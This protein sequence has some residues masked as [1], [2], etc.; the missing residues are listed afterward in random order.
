M[1]GKSHFSNNP[2]ADLGFD[3]FCIARYWPGY[4][5]SP[6][7]DADK[8]TASMYAVHWYWHPGLVA[9]GKGV[10][11]GPDDFGPDLETA[12]IKDFITRR[13]S[14]PFFVYYPVNLS[15][16]MVRSTNSPTSPG[17]RWNYTDVPE[18]DAQGNKTGKRI[19]GSL[20][21]DLEYVDFL[22]GQIWAQVVA[23]G[24]D[25]KTI[26]MV[27]GDN[28]TAGYGKGKLTSEVALRVPFIVYGPGQVKRTGPCDALVDFADILP[29]LAELAG[30][31]FPDGYALDGK[32]FAPLL[33]GKP[34]TGREWIH[35][36]LGTARWLRDQRW[37]LDGNGTFYDCGNS[38]DETAGYRDVTASTDPEVVAARKRFDTIL[39]TIPAPDRNDPDIGPALMRF[40]QRIK[41]A[42]KAE[43]SSPV[44]GKKSAHSISDPMGSSVGVQASACSGD[45]LKRE[46]QQKPARQSAGS[47]RPLVGAIRWDGWFKDNQWEKNLTDAKW[48]SRLPF[49]ATVGKSGKV[50]VC[51]DSQAVM[52][53]E[54]AYAKAGGLSYWAFC[55]YHSKSKAQVNPYNYGW[56]RYLASKH[57]DGFNFCLL[58]QGP[59]LGPTNE[60]E[61]TVAQFVKLF[62]EPTYQRVCGD[63]PLL[64]V[65]SCDKLIPH[66]GSAKAAGDAFRRLRAASEKGGTG[67]PYI[68]AQIWPNQTAADFLDA[69]GFDA[70]GAYS[71][72]GDTN[73]SADYKSLVAMNRW[74]WNQYKTTGREVVPLVNAGWDGRPRGYPGAW[75]EQAT[76]T[77]VADAVK[78]ALDWNRDNPKTARAQTVLVY[79]WNEY[80]EGGWLCPTIAEGDARLKAVKE[81]VDAYPR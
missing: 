69:I 24:L 39:K 70:L 50:C 7:A 25:Q 72:H 10:P 29:T 64:Y 54:I 43:R 62:K 56:K 65:Y 17:A 79:A 1:F 16:Q 18:R 6:Q 77:E 31:K 53:R 48:R 8:G 32:S 38:R 4:D 81:M 67:N 5:G 9:D 2:K 41:G 28:G 26:L 49:F 40:E 75:Y 12:R 76:P 42:G 68:V 61:A 15:H 59:H 71:A 22:V 44:R 36:F 27:T 13:K 73:S 33:Q 11:T 14:Q 45:T 58:L 60:W 74:Y 63:R 19:K 66:F 23:E 51:G 46:L 78:A 80:D 20:K 30:A 47:D 21:A 34:F 3:E 37:L 57:K 35:S 55:Y 52:D